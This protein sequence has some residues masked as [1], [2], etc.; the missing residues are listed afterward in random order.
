MP[1]G[2]C[3]NRSVSQAQVPANLQET[4]QNN[5]YS[6]ARHVLI[7]FLVVGT[8]AGG[9]WYANYFAIAA[10]L[11]SACLA[12]AA[13]IALVA[14]LAIAKK[15]SMTNTISVQRNL[16]QFPQQPPT[17]PKKENPIMPPPVT[18]P[19]NSSREAIA[20]PSSAAISTSASS[21]ASN[22]SANAGSE[23]SSPPSSSSIAAPSSAS[24]SM[25]SENEHEPIRKG[26]RS[27]SEPPSTPST[28][29]SSIPPQTPSITS[30]IGG[31]DISHEAVNKFINA[32]NAKNDTFKQL[33]PTDLKLRLSLL[34]ALRD[35]RKDI[36]ESKTALMIYQAQQTADAWG[37]QDQ[38]SQVA[39][40]ISLKDNPQF[41]KSD[42]I[43][44]A[45]ETIKNHKNVK[46]ITQI[47]KPKK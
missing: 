19:A 11:S 25:E 31:S 16:I 34:N 26:S 17:P 38:Q 33:I 6:I 27:I 30:T 5:S 9:A 40:L 22:T 36:K 21:S 44:K 46:E 8:L 23:T 14:S 43:N 39:C 35:R 7:T 42:K 28:G 12:G 2:L 10:P 20:A 13:L 4:N 41:G 45:L 47:L 3:C 1:I 29:T 32:L 15:N 37:T 24:P 18:L